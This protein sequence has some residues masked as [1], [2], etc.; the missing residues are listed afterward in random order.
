MKIF[1][2]G[3]DIASGNWD[4]D[5]DGVMRSYAYSQQVNLNHHLTNVEVVQAKNDR[6]ISGTASAAALGTLVAGP[7]GTIAGAAFGGKRDKETVV[8]CE[9]SDGSAFVA[10]FDGVHL[11]HFLGCKTGKPKSGPAVTAIP[12]DVQ[13]EHQRNE[14]NKS[15]EGVFFFFVA[16]LIVSWFMA[17]T[18]FWILLGLVG[19]V[20]VGVLI[21]SFGERIDG[22][23]A[24]LR[25]NLAGFR[26]NRERNKSAKKNL[27][28]LK[29]QWKEERKALKGGRL[30]EFLE[31]QAL[32]GNG[33]GPLELAYSFVVGQVIRVRPG[34]SFSAYRALGNDQPHPDYKLDIDLDRASLWLEKAMAERLEK[35]T[36]KRVDGRLLQSSMVLGGWSYITPDDVKHHLSNEPDIQS[37]YDEVLDKLVNTSA[38]YEE[39]V[40][41]YEKY[42][43]RKNAKDVGKLSEKI[44]AAEA[45]DDQIVSASD[46]LKLA[47]MYTVGIGGEKDLTKATAFFEKAI[48]QVPVVFPENLR[49]KNLQS[50]ESQMMRALSKGRVENAG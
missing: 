22:G 15:L 27:Q 8:A 29:R 39:Y 44:A 13:D 1:V 10:K 34:S 36:S 32:M 49:Q 50:F 31:S 42:V 14:S 2:T 37:R 25:R 43:N 24:G 46:Y 20:G 48:A 45:D 11:S 4:L 12:S 17:R 41:A 18:F 16:L 21:L 3:G 7:L 47:K 35:M 23:V 5:V 38:T 9:L 40:T 33:V 26:Q 6:T 28:D 30:V 19:V